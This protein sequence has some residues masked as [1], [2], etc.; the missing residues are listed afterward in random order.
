MSNEVF[1]WLQAFPEADPAA[2]IDLFPDVL[3]GSVAVESVSGV[4]FQVF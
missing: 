3:H 2:P 4:T 1:S